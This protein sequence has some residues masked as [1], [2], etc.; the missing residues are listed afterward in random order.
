MVF[1]SITFLFYFLPISL[2]LWLPFARR[3]NLA[4]IVLLGISLL[5][6]AWG[7]PVFVVIMLASI[8][9]NYV[10]GRLIAAGRRHRTLWL[11]LGVTGNLLL[12]GYF[13][14]VG[15]LFE[16]LFE[17]FG[18][19]VTTPQVHLPL[20]ISFFTFQ[21]ITY[22]VDVKRDVVPV[23]KN[24]KN[25]ALYIAL[26]PQ[27]IAGPIV[28][29]CDIDK[30][31]TIREPSIPL[32][33]DGARRFIVGLS[34][35]VLIAN[36][37][38]TVADEIFLMNTDALTSEL[39]L[40]AIVSYTFQI[41]F[42]FSGYSDMAIGL[43]KMFG[44]KFPEN[45]NHPY[46]ARSIQDF[47]HRWH[48]SLSTFFRDYLYIPLGGNRKGKLRTLVNL[49]A[50]FLLCGLWH[51]AAWTFVLWGAYHG[52]FLVIER[53]GLGKVLQ[54]LPSFIGIAYTLVVVMLGWLLFRAESLTQ[55]TTMLDVLFTGG[56]ESH[57]IHKKYTKDILLLVT[58]AAAF[59]G[60]T[61]LISRYV[62]QT[63]HWGMAVISDVFLFLCFVLSVSYLAA[64][65]YNPFIYF[66]F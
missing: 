40:V 44:F 33:A 52:L 16:V 29:Y 58:T 51:G 27:L 45:F 55:F 10:F 48:I 53:I 50:V 41:Y 1:S 5:F 42:D 2:L 9:L 32:F 49:W 37:F 24:I 66:R 34:K 18:I 26:F 39:V 22:L 47:W 46:I 63:K 6:Y 25:L 43:G 4:N 17:V 8:A 11:T 57:N 60:S 54:K 3:N 31:L 12:L 7:E 62:L 13:K 65:T 14:Y 64:G 35:K 30:Q 21:A 15:F 38:A 36:T 20:G 28:R 61:P 23:Q 19:S 59:I 56:L